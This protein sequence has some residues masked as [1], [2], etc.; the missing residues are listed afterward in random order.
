MS[1][2]EKDIG[3]HGVATDEASTLEIPLEERLQNDRLPDP[4]LTH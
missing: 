1:G 3:F 4:P 2:E